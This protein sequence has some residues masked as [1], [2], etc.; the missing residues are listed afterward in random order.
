MVSII[1]DN[2]LTT[3]S[4]EL[5]CG[6]QPKEIF[7]WVSGKKEKLKDLEPISVELDKN[8]RETLLTS[9]NM[10][11]ELSS[12]P[13]VMFFKEILKKANLMDLVYMNGKMVWFMKETLSK[14]I[15][16]EKEK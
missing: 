5:E 6:N 3:K 8:T 13:V 1:L 16:Q 4:M 14:V 15:D 9:W 2:G 10:E 12:F 7:I 11:K